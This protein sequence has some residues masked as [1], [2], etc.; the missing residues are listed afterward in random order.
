MMSFLTF[1]VVAGSSAVLL[2]A[3]LILARLSAYRPVPDASGSAAPEGRMS[4]SRSAKYQP[5]ARLL[6]E[7]DFQFLK[8]QPGY[9]PAIGA[10]LLRQRRR[11]FRLYLRELAADFHRLHAEAREIVAN[12]QQ[13]DAD[14]VWVLMRQQVTFWRVMTGDRNA[15]VDGPGRSGPCGSARSDGRLRGD[16]ARSEA[17]P[18]SRCHAA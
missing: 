6:A 12:S 5:M 10:R 7:E 14:L 1:G 18:G 2:L 11:I 17:V 13:P 8:S 3:G 15:A 9:R 4:H 16:S